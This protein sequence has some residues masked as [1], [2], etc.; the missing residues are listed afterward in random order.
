MDYKINKIILFG[1]TGMLGRYIYSFFNE[2]ADYKVVTI[3]SR[4]TIESLANIDE[5]LL[6]HD[7]DRQT[8]IINCIGQIPQRT[9]EN[10]DPK[11]YFLINSIFPYL[12]WNS[13]KKYGAKMIQPTT[14]CVFSGKKIGGKYSE[15]DIHDESGLYGMS[16]SIGEPLDCTV[17]RTSIIGRELL[18]KKSFMEWVLNS[19]DEIN[20]WDNHYWN[21]ITCLEYCHLILTII[22]TDSFWKGIRHIHSP[23]IVSK[24][25]MACFIK[26]V[27]DLKIKINKVNSTE[28]VNKTLISNYDNNFVK[29]TILE[30]IRELYLF[31]LID[32]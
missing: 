26:D 32:M 15:T 12:L 11:C 17:I 21:G 7:I 28:D 3:N 16:K 23:D 24:Y 8:C 20:G 30:Q 18:N 4:I 19:K 13:C 25:D 6:N 9:T 1:S 5:W 31:S 29:K 10:F 22:H 14:D 27:F 2:N